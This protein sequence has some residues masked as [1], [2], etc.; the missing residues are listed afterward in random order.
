MED[1]STFKLVALGL[2]GVVALYLIVRNTYSG[3][4]VAHKVYEALLDFLP[5]VGPSGSISSY[6][7]AFWRKG[8]RKFANRKILS[9]TPAYQMQRCRRGP[10]CFS[11]VLRPAKGTIGVL[12][13]EI[14][15]NFWLSGTS[16]RIGVY[17]SLLTVPI[18]K[19]RHGFSLPEGQNEVIRQVA[20]RYMKYAS[21]TREK[22]P[23]TAREGVFRVFRRTVLWGN[24]TYLCARL[25][26]CG[27]ENR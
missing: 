24:V 26:T 9:Y 20:V 18:Q 25:L 19:F 23:R 5:T 4:N 7:G 16:P 21:D 6:F 10:G 22:D 8:L 14:R 1:E 13:K 3:P 2:A 27:M 15:S 11:E 17:I 12:R